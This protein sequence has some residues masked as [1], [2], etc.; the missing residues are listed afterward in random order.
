MPRRSLFHRVAGSTP[1]SQPLL[2]S[3]APLSC[4]RDAPAA[5]SDG[6]SVYVVGGWD[7]ERGAFQAGRALRSCAMASG[8]DLLAEPDGT[9]ERFHGQLDHVRDHLEAAVRSA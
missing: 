9:D 2:R 7:G 6:E 5:T 8:E 1:H 4:A 3:A